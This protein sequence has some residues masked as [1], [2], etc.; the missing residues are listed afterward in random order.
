ML[1]NSEKEIYEIEG[2]NVNYED[3]PNEEGIYY[4]MTA[5]EIENDVV[6]CSVARHKEHIVIING[7][8]SCVRGNAK[9]G[10]DREGDPYIS[11]FHARHF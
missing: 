1:H 11:L 8:V 9:S 5:N 4:G 7:Y 2:S 3:R 10:E 6:G